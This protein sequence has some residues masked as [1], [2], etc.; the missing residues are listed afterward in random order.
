MAAESCSST[1][2]PTLLVHENDEP[3]SR[4]DLILLGGMTTKH[5]FV[6]HSML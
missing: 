4:R 1:P 2:T 6:V 5:G 3:I